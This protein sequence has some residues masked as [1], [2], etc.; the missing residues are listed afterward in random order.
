MAPGILAG[1]AVSDATLPSA[2]PE[3][4]QTS[5]NKPVGQLFSLADT[6]TVVT[7]AG[8]GLGITFARAILEAGGNVACLDVLPEPSKEEWAGLGK[9]AKQSG[10]SV[11]YHRCDITKEGELANV[12]KEVNKKAQALNAPLRGTVACAGI[13]QKVP[14]LDYPAEDFE[15]MLRVN[16][17]GAFLTAKHAARTM[18]ENGTGGSIVLIASMSGNI[19]NRGLT[20]TAYNSSK[21]AVQQMCRSVAQEWGQYGIRVNTLSPGYIRTAMTDALLQA[22]PEVEKTWMAGALLGRLGAP[23][24]FKAAIVFLLGPGSSLMTGADLRIDGG[25]C[26]ESKPSCSN[27][28]RTGERCHWNRRLSFLPQNAFTVDENSKSTRVKVARQAEDRRKAKFRTIR[29]TS[30]EDASNAEGEIDIDAHGVEA[31]DHDEVAVLNSEG[32][33]PGPS[34]DLH[35]LYASFHRTIS[36]NPTA[37]IPVQSP[38][39]TSNMP[40]AQINSQDKSM[41]GSTGVPLVLF[42]PN[43]P[44]YATLG[45]TGFESTLG[46]NGT[47]LPGT[48][49]DLQLSPDMLTDDGIFL[50]GSRYQALHNTLRNHV[51]ITA[52]SAQPSREASP[53]DQRPEDNTSPRTLPRQTPT[54]R[55]APSAGAEEISGTN[56]KL[57]PNQEYILWN[58]WVVEIAGWKLDKFDARKHFRHVLPIMAKTCSHLRFSMLALSARQ[59]ER[60]DGSL[61]A[62]ISLALYQEAIHKLLPELHTKDI[63]VVA[64]CVVLCVL[65]MLSC[66]PKAWRRHLDGC[67]CLMRA[68][69]IRG[70]SGGVEEALFWCFARMDVCGGLISNERTL[71]PVDEWMSTGSFEADCEAFRARSLKV[72]EEHANYSCYLVARVL[73]FLFGSPKSR[74]CLHEIFGKDQPDYDNKWVSLFNYLEEWYA[75]R[76]PEMHHLLSLNPGISEDGQTS[77]FPTILYGSGAAISGNQLHHTG[78]LLMLQHIP[79]DVPRKSRSVLW[80]ARQICAISISNAHHG[81]WTNSVQPLWLAGQVMSHPAEHR[82][83]IEVYERIERETGWGATWRAEDLKHHWGELDD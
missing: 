46:P 16:V 44:D 21:A 54:F 45:T 15:R 2:V 38:S 71:I 83:I 17:T 43:G 20:C 1:S 52:R 22:E 59:L 64:S 29:G 24:D 7:G 6:T 3:T 41:Q 12:F 73:H 10:L 60:K 58:N 65:E 5:A 78:A 69:N 9:L 56:V 48:E 47:A 39:I 66:S 30:N 68:M 14:A 19:A 49:P 57:T 18:V 76:P 51:F 40:R 62:S 81:S 4:R 25:H 61:P 82:A 34:H 80:H 23:E 79:K 13:Q 77:P 8:R 33:V 67:A 42:G 37:A 36:P 35:D 72:F 70:D 28:R 50:P 63:T 27:C 26:D 55:L 74:D 53:G 31:F 32:S 11:T 75:C